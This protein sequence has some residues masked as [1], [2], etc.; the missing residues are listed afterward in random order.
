MGLAQFVNLMA[1]IK[2]T[3]PVNT[4]EGIARRLDRQFRDLAGPLPVI[5][6]FSSARL[7][8]DRAGGASVPIGIG[9]GK[10]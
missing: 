1:G 10:A 4:S 2:N 6:Q 9:L 7:G 8:S 3:G 5:L